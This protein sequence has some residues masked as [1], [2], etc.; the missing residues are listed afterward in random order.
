MMS[1]DYQKPELRVLD[2][3]ASKVDYPDILVPTYMHEQT[4]KPQS[5]LFVDVQLNSVILGAAGTWNAQLSTVGNNPAIVTD[6]RW[7][8]YLI[9]TRRDQIGMVS[10]QGNRHHEIYTH[11]ALEHHA[12]GEVSEFTYHRLHFKVG[13]KETCTAVSHVTQDDMPSL[14]SVKAA[15]DLLMSD[16]PPDT[17]FQ[18]AYDQFIEKMQIVN[19]GSISRMY[20]VSES[21]LDKLLNHFGSRYTDLHVTTQPE[22][23]TLQV[24]SASSM[25]KN[26]FTLFV[27]VGD[28]HFS[29]LS[30]HLDCSS[31][32]I[33]VGQEI[34]LSS[35][36]NHSMFSKQGAHDF[37]KVFDQDK[38]LP[39]QLHVRIY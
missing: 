39:V 8:T 17:I 15:Q 24:A 38:A 18:R 33:A 27:S 26:Q 1:N 6:H 20:I 11:S 22:W 37:A 14:E 23:D 7:S 25:R 2:I 31:F 13:D 28:A 19:A 4:S 12:T 16:D 21:L 30:H 34:N 32:K 29:K 36:A 35:I 3:G 5:L 9:D 10:I